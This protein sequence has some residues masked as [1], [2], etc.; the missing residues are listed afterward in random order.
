MSWSSVIL[1]RIWPDC[2]MRMSRSVICLAFC[3]LTSPI[4]D[5]VVVLNIPRASKVR[6]A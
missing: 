3:G 5:T 2:A 4:L 1:P 6:G